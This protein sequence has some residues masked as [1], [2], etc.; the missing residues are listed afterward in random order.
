MIYS[1][2]N[3]AQFVFKASYCSQ[4]ITKKISNVIFYYDRSDWGSRGIL[5]KDM[6]SLELWNRFKTD[7]TTKIIINFFDDFICKVDIDHIVDT[8]KEKQLDSSR[9]FLIVPDI[10]YLKFVKEQFSQAGVNINIQDYN[11]SLKKIN[12]SYIK[13]YDALSFKRFSMLSRNYRDIRLKFYATLQQKELL[14]NCAY[15]FNNIDPY[16]RPHKVFD[17]TYIK[18][19]IN[20]FNITVDDQWIDNIPYAVGNIDNKIDRALY[21]II[22]N[23]GIHIIIESHF[24]HFVNYYG[25]SIQHHDYAPSF[26]TEKTYKPISRSK[27]FIFF[28]APYS[29]EALKNMGFKTFSPFINEDYD[30]I[31]DNEKRLEMVVQEIERICSLSEKDFVKLI[32]DTKDITDYNFKLLF[33][34]LRTIKFRDE[35]AWINPM[36]K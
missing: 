30:Q 34:L 7:S 23:S 5:F 28:S 31:E 14:N 22:D 13:E 19:K 1:I 17:K 33:G 21:D 2:S 15:T 25:P 16:V 32:E 24:D 3:S 4:H 20:E 11:G 6:L 8:I 26:I 9:I 35:F 10:N 12:F 36:I 18:Q 27:P 29:L